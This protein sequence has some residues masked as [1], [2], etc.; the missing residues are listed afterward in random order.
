MIFSESFACVDHLSLSGKLLYHVV[1]MFFVQ[2]PE[3][4]PLYPKSIYT[5]RLKEDK[6]NNNK[7]SNTITVNSSGSVFVTVGSTSFDKLIK[8]IDKIEFIEELQK[9][10]FSKLIVQYGRGTYIPSCTLNSDQNFSCEYYRFKDS[11]KP[12]IDNASLV[13]SHAGKNVMYDSCLFVK[14]LDLY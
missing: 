3:L 12:D 1:D 13:I 10:G 11:I 8:T 7:L 4:I 2:W 6:S 14:E 5:G 9:Q